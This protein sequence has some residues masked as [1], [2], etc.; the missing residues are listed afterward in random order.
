MGIRCGCC[1]L[2]F[3]GLCMTIGLTAISLAQGRTANEK[4]PSLSLKANPMVAF[5]PAKVALSAEV[6]GGANDNEEFYCP[7]IEWE[8][9]DETF[10][11]SK[12]DCAPYEAGKS[13]IRRRFTTT[14]VY[15]LEGSYNITLRLKKKDKVIASSTVNVQIRPGLSEFNR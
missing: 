1:R 3:A 4:R 10:S 2:V 6:K 7:A 11:E 9:G 12:N 8:W 14:R 13:E 5:A 15:K